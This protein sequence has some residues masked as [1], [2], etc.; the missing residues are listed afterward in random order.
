M[1]D[2]AKLIGSALEEVKRK[3]NKKPEEMPTP[4]EQAIGELTQGAKQ[5]ISPT[6]MPEAPSQGSPIGAERISSELQ[7]N[8]T[9]QGVA[10]EPSTV[11]NIQTPN[12][13]TLLS[14]LSAEDKTA[15]S[16]GMITPP[17]PVTPQERNT[18]RL[19]ADINK[20]QEDYR[21]AVDAPIQKQSFWKD[22]GAK[23]VQGADAF[24]NGTRTPIVGWGKLKHDAAVDRAGAKLNPL[25]G[26]RKQQQETDLTNARIQN[27][28]AKPTDRDLDR[29]QKDRATKAASERVKMNIEFRQGVAK[30]YI[31]E[32]GRVW[33]Q[34][35]ND[36]SRPMEP[37]ENPITHEQEF[38]PGEEGVQ[39]TDPNTKQTYTIK[40]K[41]GVMP[42][43]TI[44]TGNANRQTTANKD[45]A[46]KFWQTQKENISN[47][48]KYMSDVNSLLASAITAESGISDDPGTRAE[49]K[50]KYDEISALSNSPLPEG[51]D[52][53]ALNKAQE[54]RV[55]RVNKLVDDYNE[56]NNKLLGNIS[57]SEAGK[58]KAEQIRGLI[59][60]MPKPGKLTYTP[61]KPTL[62]EGGVVTGKPVPKEKD[63]MG[64]FR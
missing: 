38:V 23:L 14:P 35:L 48:M 60:N 54:D 45:N 63:P 39:W 58:A 32:N 41:Q 15:M 55:K 17:P 11:D 47:Q 34:F 36:P 42:S 27:E 64:L 25:L 7:Q 5:A 37:L 20:A 16:S 50:G 22:F 51:L 12:M 43:A 46:E 59:N 56:L 40:A 30:P 44:A 13:G 24:F 18:Q 9:A 28:L 4:S 62:V 2:F 21:T 3:P 52:T 10:D 61:Y 6:A 31:D 53:D 1:L 49:M 19:D 29:A 26:M 33:K 8:A 57:K